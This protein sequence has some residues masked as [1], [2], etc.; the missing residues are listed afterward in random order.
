MVRSGCFSLSGHPKRKSCFVP[1]LW[2]PSPPSHLCFFLV[3][4]L[5]QIHLFFNHMKVPQLRLDTKPQKAPSWS[6][7]RP[8]DKVF[9]LCCL[10]V[11]EMK[12][13]LTFVFIMKFQEIASFCCCSLCWLDNTNADIFFSFLKLF[14]VG[15]QAHTPPTQW[16]CHFVLVMIGLN[17]FL[18][19]IT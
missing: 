17:F 1:S 15:Y 8:L 14:L 5:D 19:I 10:F 6:R 11:F 2:F 7:K 3:N 12:I 16:L 9:A 13:T 18:I 4:F